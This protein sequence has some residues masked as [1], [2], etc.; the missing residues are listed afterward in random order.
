MQHING[1]SKIGSMCT[2]IKDTLILVVRR[3]LDYAS[4]Q[5]GMEQTFSNGQKVPCIL[6][7]LECQATVII[8]TT[9]SLR[10]FYISC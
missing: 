5:A 7:L 4:S 9:N 6:L 2:S 10:L 1:T 3:S 8:L